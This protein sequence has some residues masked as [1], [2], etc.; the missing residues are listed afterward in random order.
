MLVKKIS[1]NFINLLFIIITGLMFFL[2]LSRHCEIDMATYDQVKSLKPHQPWLYIIVAMLMLLIICGLYLFIS[3]YINNSRVIN[4][5]N[6]GAIIVITAL[7]IVWIYFNDTVPHSDQAIILDE[8]RKIAGY[9]DEPYEWSYMS[10]F[11]FMRLLV[12]FIAV[13]LKI[14][15]NSQMVFR[16]F[17]I[18]MLVFLVIGMSAITDKHI[19]DKSL[20]MLLKIAL[21]FFYPIIVYTCY[22][23][24]TLAAVTFE[25]WAFYFAVSF[26]EENDGKHKIF[27]GLGVVLCIFWGV[28][29]HMS[30]LIAMVAICIYLV[31]K[32][33]KETW[34]RNVILIISVVL[35]YLA[36]NRLVDA[37]YVAITNSPVHDAIPISAKVYMGITASETQPGGPGSQ[38]GSYW[39]MFE[40]NDMNAKK[41]NEYLWPVIGNV[42]HEYMVGERSWSFFLKKAEYQWLDPTLDARRIILL[43]NQLNGEPANS[44]IYTAFY[45][46][47]IRTIALK[48]ITAFMIM[49][50]GCAFFSAINRLINKKSDVDIHFLIQIFIVGGFMFQLIAESISRYIFSYYV[51]LLIEAFYGISILVKFNKSLRNRTNNIKSCQV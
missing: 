10:S 11:S 35:F 40:L 46:S 13:L 42:M 33:E 14:F 38:D 37:T 34:I 4:A 3:R 25:V 36:C 30:A 51:L 21:V 47:R 12:L 18:I 26:V 24:G 48:L 44:N 15:G 9:L 22:V 17:N 2:A 6:I 39:K 20:G 7:S 28:E 43:N 31:L 45:Y 27:N 29:M 23:Y 49:V 5:I 8:A 1:A 50:Y 41:T 19:K 16:W 32:T